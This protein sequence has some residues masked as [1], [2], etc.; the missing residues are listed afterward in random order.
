[1]K[2][3]PWRNRIVTLL[4]EQPVM[5]KLEITRALVPRPDPRA[6][7]QI[8]REL[9]RMVDDDDLYRPYHGHYMLK[10]VSDDG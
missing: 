6:W 4:I 9:G 2:A 1:M 8:E 5:S 3:R 7:A 10:K